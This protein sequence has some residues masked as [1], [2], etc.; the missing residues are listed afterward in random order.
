[1]H[2]V[3]RPIRRVAARVKNKVLLVANVMVYDVVVHATSSVRKI[4]NEKLL[5]LLIL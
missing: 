5:L 4:Y 3:V 2:S 1:M